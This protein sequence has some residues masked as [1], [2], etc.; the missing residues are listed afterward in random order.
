MNIYSKILIPLDGSKVAESALPYAEVLAAKFG[1]DLTLL[2]VQGT[3]VGESVIPASQLETIK[4]N[5][6]GYL[7][8]Q[9]SMLREKGLKAHAEFRI[10]DSA[11]G[12]IDYAHTNSVDQIVIATHGRS[13]LKRWLLGSTADRVIRGTEKPVLLIRAKESSPDLKEEDLFHRVTVALD[14]SEE[15]ENIIP[16]LERLA[17][18][19]QMEVILLQVITET[20][21]L[22]PVANGMSYRYMPVPQEVMDLRKKEALAYLDTI[23]ERLVAHGIAIKTMVVLGDAGA[24]V[25]DTAQQTDSGLVAMTTHGRS[26]IKRWAYGS[27]ADK[28]LHSGTRPLLLV[29]A[30]P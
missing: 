20:T 15:A 25:I 6:L 23:G 26:G 11:S 8:Q 27:V 17:S 22:E 13:G 16:H 10:D 7:E 3:V 18:R 21:F 24:G 2:G 14:G 9:A 28:V 29:R 12:I 5:T 19:F 30:A 1:A 4:T